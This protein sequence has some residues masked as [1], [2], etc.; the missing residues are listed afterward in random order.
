MASMPGERE[1]FHSRRRREDGRD[2]PELQ[3]EVEVRGGQY[4][5][6]LCFP[7][8]HLSPECPSLSKRCCA[9]LELAR[10]TELHSSC[11]I[12]G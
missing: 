8:C 3:G 1:W 9:L 6:V 12:C 4:Y 10:V 2:A 5:A 11:P 7:Y